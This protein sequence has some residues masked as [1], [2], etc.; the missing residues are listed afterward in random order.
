MRLM[1]HTRPLYA[2]I[3]AILIAQ[4]TSGVG[5]YGLLSWLPRYYNTVGR[6]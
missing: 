4:L 3:W 5:L 1:P 6:V 2:Q